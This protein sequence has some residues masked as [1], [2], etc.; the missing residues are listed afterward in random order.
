MKKIIY[1]Q[2]GDAGVLEMADVAVPAVSETTLLIK[3]K[4]VSINPLDWKIRNGE[5]KLMSGSKFP[6]GT[7]IDFSG[8][9]EA[10]GSS[11]KQYKKGDEVFGLLDVFK[12]VVLAEYIIAGE[13]DI[14]L[15]PRGISF[16]QAAAAPVV[17]SAALQ[18]FDTLLN[19]QKGTELLINGASGGIGMFAIQIAKMKGAIVTAVVSDNGLQAAKDW[20]SDFVINYRKE[21]VLKSGKLYDAI[22][23]LSNQMTYSAAKKIMKPS[24]V[25]VNTAPGP[26]EIISSFFISLFSRKKYKVLMLKPSPVYLK[27][28]A[29]YMKQGLAIVVSKAYR[30]DTFKTAYTE[31]PKA[32]IIGKL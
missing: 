27:E 20:G 24:S 8:I 26:K 12:G 4:A 9:V 2:F 7:G 6:R 1:N 29:T 19:V 22:I 17:G 32:H 30:F 21:D 16:E 14:A 31:V 11:I 13:K 5:M 3:V 23:D 18:L 10:T 25:Y 15:K 28:L